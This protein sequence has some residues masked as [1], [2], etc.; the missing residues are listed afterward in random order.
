MMMRFLAGVSLSGLALASSSPDAQVPDMC[1]LYFDF[2]HTNL[3]SMHFG[4]A[5]D[6]GLF[7]QRSDIGQRFDPQGRVAISTDGSAFAMT[8]KS[9]S[10]IGKNYGCCDPFSVV[11][12][13]IQTGKIISEQSL[14]RNDAVQGA[15]CGVHGCGFL[16][17]GALDVQAKT[18]VAWVEP[19][20]SQPPPAPSMPPAPA[21]RAL[22]KA[23]RKLQTYGTGM[24]LVEFDLESADAYQIRPFGTNANDPQELSPGLMNFDDPGNAWYACGVDF[25]TQGICNVE[26]TTTKTPAKIKMTTW[27]DSSKFQ[28]T[29]MKY[30]KQL[31]S[32]I[33]LAQG[34]GEATVATTIYQV[35]VTSKTPAFTK[36]LDLGLSY[37][38]LHQ[39]SISA[40][41]KYLMVIMGTVNTH[42][43]TYT[44]LTVDLVA[45]KVVKSIEMKHPKFITPLSLMPCQRSSSSVFV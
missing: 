31:K 42:L 8:T 19:L 43:P 17:I 40:D 35:D 34:L 7:H 38:T 15:N 30:S 41:G 45:K 28:I 5:S 16:E 10:T 9:N 18:L 39:M 24:S 3:S 44:L 4:V 22:P 37:V 23:S 29:D 11:A 27:K 25:T 13:D 21:P 20:L 1:A 32:V 36:M 6:D 33:V 26:V 12:V 14:K 2:T